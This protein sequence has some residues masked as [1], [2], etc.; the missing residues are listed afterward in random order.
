[1]AGFKKAVAGFKQAMAGFRLGSAG[2]R[3][4]G[5]LLWFVEPPGF[6][7]G[8]LFARRAKAWVRS[9]KTHFFRGSENRGTEKHGTRTENRGSRGSDC[10]WACISGCSMADAFE[11]AAPFLVWRR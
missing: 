11:G 2:F 10:G 5:K 8:I 4:S 3:V 1:M 6:V 7:S 9:A